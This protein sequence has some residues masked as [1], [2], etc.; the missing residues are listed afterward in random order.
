MTHTKPTEDEF[1][2]DENG[3]THLPTGA[4][5]E[6]YPGKPLHRVTPS[7]LGSVLADGRDYRQEEVLEM[8]QQ[9]WAAELKHRGYK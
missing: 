3:V 6:A 4:W 9:V 1:R 2:I 5:F 7:M 8:A